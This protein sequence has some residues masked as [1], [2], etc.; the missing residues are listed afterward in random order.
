M[1]E[2]NTITFTQLKGFGAAKT[3]TRRE[4]GFCQPPGS[5]PA[6]TGSS[7]KRAVQGRAEGE[8]QKEHT[9]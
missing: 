5:N 9:Y 6:R 2:E 4:K 3:P 7:F 1:E 8:M